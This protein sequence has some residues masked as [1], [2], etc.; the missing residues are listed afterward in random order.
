[1]ARS[2]PITLLASAAELA[3]VG[4]SVAARGGMGA[5]TASPS[6]VTYDGHPPELFVTDTK[7]G[8]T[9]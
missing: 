9:T 5:A 4:P 3:L 2:R 7:A 8:Q 6:Q 1:M